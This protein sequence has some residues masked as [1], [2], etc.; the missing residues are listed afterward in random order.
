MPDM[1]GLAVIQFRVLDEAGEL[2]Q[3][4]FMHF[5]VES[6][7]LPDKMEVISIPAA[8]FTEAEWSKRQWNVREG[9]KVNGAGEGFFTYEI[10]LPE[11]LRSK[12]IREAAIIALAGATCYSCCKFPR[13]TTLETADVPFE[14]GWREQ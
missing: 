8:E 9:R 2:L 11:E 4:N 13:G 1:A 14:S 10:A 3:R 12:R 7:R 5:E 6:D